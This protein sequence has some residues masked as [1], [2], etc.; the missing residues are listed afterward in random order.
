MTANQTSGPLPA[1]QAEFFLRRLSADRNHF[2]ACLPACGRGGVAFKGKLQEKR[3]ALA[4]RM[5]AREDGNPWFV[6]PAG[7]VPEQRSRK[8]HPDE[9]APDQDLGY[10]RS[11]ADARTLRDPLLPGRRLS[12]HQRA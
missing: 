9:Q 1:G 4:T 12:R 11:M 8:S 3:H 7:P 5:Q 6:A 10:M 2:D